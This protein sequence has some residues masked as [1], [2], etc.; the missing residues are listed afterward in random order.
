MTGTVNKS[1][2]YDLIKTVT[3][4][5]VVLAH[6]A[7]MYTPSGAIRIQGE[8]AF[9]AQ[10][11]NYIYSFHMP[12]F[13]MLSGCV[14]GWCINRGK[15]AHPI[16][17]LKNK[18]KKLLIPYLAFGVLWVAPVMC[19]LKLTADGFLRYVWTGILLSL[20]ARHLWY[21]VAL[22]W[23][24]GIFMFLRPAILRGTGGLVMAGVL[25]V[26]MYLIS[27]RV[28]WTLQ[29][30]QVF[31]YAMFFWLGI[32]VDRY[33]DRLEQLARRVWPAAFLLP[34]VL[35]AKPVFNINRLTDCGYKLV[36]IA[37]MLLLGWL[38][39]RRFPEIPDHRAYRCLNRNAFGI[40]L[41]HPM[42]IYVLFT[43]TN[44]LALPPV[45]L[46]GGIFAVAMIVSVLL[47]ELTRKLR[48]GILMGE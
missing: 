29:M 28:P 1:R 31:S 37:M 7:V 23:I 17:F 2:L 45:V 48:L 47:T 43:V 20:N 13:V 14:Y 11:S 12:L 16:A 30:R 3:T 42:I 25:T 35:L 39:L 34:L 26:G 36:G 22:F 41:F 19:L 21:L 10:M 5:L 18:A 9:L 15:Y 40:Y 38:T 8:S 24:F 33:Y 4:V 27:G 46:S 44:G 32:A 6:V